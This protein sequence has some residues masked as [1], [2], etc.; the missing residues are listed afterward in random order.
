MQ[1]L[2]AISIRPSRSLAFFLVDGRQSAFDLV[3]DDH[4]VDE[5]DDGFLIFGFEVLQGSESFEQ[6]GVVQGSVVVCSLR[7][8]DYDK[9]NRNKDFRAMYETVYTVRYQLCLL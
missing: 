1:R 9:A 5:F 4:G 2:I 8:Q 3:L 6:V 7:N